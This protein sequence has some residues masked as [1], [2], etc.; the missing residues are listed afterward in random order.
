VGSRGH[1]SKTSLAKDSG[2]RADLS[3][4][5]I[6]CLMSL[7]MPSP[8][9]ASGLKTSSPQGVCLGEQLS[10]KAGV[11]LVSA[12]CPVPDLFPPLPGAPVAQHV[13]T[14]TAEQANG[15]VAGK[16]ACTRG[17]VGLV[18]I[19]RPSELPPWAT[20]EPHDPF[21]PGQGW[22]EERVVTPGAA[23]GLSQ[24]SQALLPLAVCGQVYGQ[25]DRRTDGAASSF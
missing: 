8:P 19:C 11:S 10:T 3:C 22:Q 24:T 5:C 6:A 25:T 1:S 7:P 15:S 2:S 21:L 13:R 14:N 4:C 9:S 12:R 20:A 17:T 18:E 16:G 23:E